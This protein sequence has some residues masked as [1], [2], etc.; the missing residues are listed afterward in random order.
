MT[1][2]TFWQD[3]TRDGAVGWD[4]FIL[5]YNNGLALISNKDKNIQS[6]NVNAVMF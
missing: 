1:R 4:I 2:T 6:C 3:S 5:V